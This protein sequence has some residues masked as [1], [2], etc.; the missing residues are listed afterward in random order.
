MQIV[1]GN[2]A[3]SHSWPWQA[4][5]RYNGRHVCGGS[6]ISKRHIITASHCFAVTSDPKFFSVYVG[7]QK[8]LESEPDTEQ[9]LPVEIIIKHPR[10]AQ[11]SKYDSDIAIV[12]VK[13]PGITFN[14]FV[15]PICLPNHFVHPG[16]MCY[17]TG[18]GRTMDT[19]GDGLLKQANVPTI[20]NKECRTWDPRI[21]KLLTDNM[22]FN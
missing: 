12:R 8:E 10:Y 17:V 7:K 1:G 4:S 6:V 11:A 15:S 21:D 13:F 18:F 19:G 22:V 5:I 9:I 16:Q 20:A 3:D 2:V 14:S